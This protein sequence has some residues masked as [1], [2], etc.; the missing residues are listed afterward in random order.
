MA[1]SV[2]E[3]TEFFMLLNAYL[4]SLLLL[5]VL[6]LLPLIFW[7]VARFYEGRKVENKIQKSIMSRYFYYQVVNVVVSVG[8]GTLFSNYQT[9]SEQPENVIQVICK[10]DPLF[11]VY[12]TNF[13]IVKAFTGLPL[14]CSGHGLSY[15]PFFSRY[16]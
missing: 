10:E 16:S 15:R 2:Y 6:A 1:S 5:I 4:A 13:I 9:V 7:L 14:K 3:D 11:S 8:M 12:F